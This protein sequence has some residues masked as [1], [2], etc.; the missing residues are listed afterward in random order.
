MDMLQSV[1]KFPTNINYCLSF[2]NSHADSGYRELK[3]CVIIVSIYSFY[4]KIRNKLAV[5]IC[6]NL[7]K[8]KCIQISD[9]SE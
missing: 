5:K 6:K 8:L 7:I 1:M 9:D 3:K 2:V 4:H